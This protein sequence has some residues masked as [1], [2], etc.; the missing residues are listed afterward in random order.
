ME[1]YLSTEMKES[2]IEQNFHN[3]KIKNFIYTDEY[4]KVSE[5]KYVTVD[6]IGQK[7]HRLQSAFGLIF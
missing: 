5:K 3:L 1:T 4:C 2:W 7:F 6:I